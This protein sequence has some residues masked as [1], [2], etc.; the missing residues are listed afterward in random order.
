M[1]HKSKPSGKYFSL[2]HC[3]SAKAISRPHW[4][5][6]GSGRTPASLKSRKMASM[7]VVGGPCL[8]S[9]EACSRSRSSAQRRPE[10]HASKGNVPP[11]QPPRAA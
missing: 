10:L 4:C 5:R 8:I 3:E 6:Q 9:P 1:S 7:T 11:S 2:I